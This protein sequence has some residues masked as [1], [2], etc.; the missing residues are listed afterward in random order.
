[1][2]SQFQEATHEDY[3]AELDDPD[4][5]LTNVHP[6]IIYQHIVDQY[7]KID[8]LMANNNQKQ[9]N[10]PMDPSKPLAVH[11]KSRNTVKHLLPMLA[12]QSAWQTWC[13]K[14]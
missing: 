14:G 12:I 2:R 6:S 5:G 3:L 7:A 13:K 8:L 4:D 11:T 10:T 1:M 9:F